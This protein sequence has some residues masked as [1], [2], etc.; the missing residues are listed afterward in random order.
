M[1]EA[2]RAASF[3]HQQIGSVYSKEGFYGIIK[4]SRY[5]QDYEQAV[6]RLAR[7]IVDVANRLRIEP[8]DPPDYRSSRNAFDRIPQPGGRRIRLMVAAHDMRS[9]PDDRNPFYY[10]PTA[11]DWNPYRPKCSQ[12]LAEHAAEVTRRHRY[13]PTISMLEEGRPNLKADKEPEAPGLLLVDLW[14]AASADRRSQLSQ[15]DADSQEWESV[16]VPM[17][18]E[19][20]ETTGAELFLKSHLSQVLNRMLSRV[21]PPPDECHAAREGIPSIEVFDEI[22]P[23]MAAAMS[24]RYLRTAPPYPPSGPHIKKPLL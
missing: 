23:K 21:P 15:F 4:L 12:T 17:N 20:R 19:D 3:D 5:R 24:R 22:L 8:S 6:R 18:R 7:R 1:P 13:R 16:L 9:L 2:A 14:T 10:G 11:G